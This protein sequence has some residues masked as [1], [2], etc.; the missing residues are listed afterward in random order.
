MLYW[1]DAHL[2]LEIDDD[3]LG[4]KFDSAT[5][6]KATIIH[7]TSDVLSDQ[8][9]MIELAAVLRDAM[10]LEQPEITDGW[11]AENAQLMSD[12]SQGW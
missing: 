2:A 4:R 10:G 11:R 3:P 8:D 6:P 9:A 12:L 1:P 7:V 5:D